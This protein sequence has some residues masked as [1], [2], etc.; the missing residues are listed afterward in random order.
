[1]FTE[2]TR[3]MP[4]KF[5]R[6]GKVDPIIEE[7]IAANCRVPEMVLGDLHAI[8]GTHRIGAKR[9]QEFLDDYEPG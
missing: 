5:Y 2:G 9:I 1:M 6:A 4:N 8:V 3:L 7:F